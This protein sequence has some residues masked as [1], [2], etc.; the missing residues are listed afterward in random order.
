MRQIISMSTSSRVTMLGKDSIFSSLFLTFAK[1]YINPKFSSNKKFKISD[2]WPLNKKYDFAYREKI[3]EKLIKTAQTQKKFSVWKILF[4]GIY[5]LWIFAFICAFIA[6]LF[7]LYIPIGVD[8]FIKWL[9]N[10]EAPLSEGALIASGL[11]ISSLFFFIGKRLAYNRVWILVSSLGL[12]MKSLIYK[13]I[14]QSRHSLSSELTLGKTSNMV[15]NDCNN[16]SMT[17]FYWHQICINPFF[18]LVY[19]LLLFWNFGLV[20]L[21]ALVSGVLAVLGLWFFVFWQNVWT[22]RRKI[23]SDSRGQLF[24]LVMENMKFVKF[25]NW[26]D[27]LDN[28]IRSSR[29]EELRNLRM[30][31]F[32]RGFCGGL[33]TLTPIFMIVPSLIYYFEKEGKVELNNV[34]K[35]ISIIGLMSNPLLGCLYGINGVVIVKIVSERFSRLLKIKPREKIEDDQNVDKGEVRLENLEASYVGKEV[36][37]EFYKGQKLKKVLKGVDAIFEAGKTYCITG[38][39][40]S[41]KSA[42][43]DSILGD[44][45]ILK[46]FVKKNGKIAVSSQRSCL[47]SS[48]I[49]EN[50]ILDAE[51][52]EE[53]LKKVIELAQLAEDIENLPKGD[54]SL[55]GDNGAKLSGGQKQRICLARALYQGGDIYIF[56]DAFCGLDNEVKSEI[57][58][59]A[60]FGFLKRKTIIIVS[61]S[62]EVMRGA[63]EIIVVEQGKIVAKGNFEQVLAAG[64]ILVESN[65]K[66]IENVEFTK[67][68][69]DFEKIGEE[70]PKG[71]SKNSEKSSLSLVTPKDLS[72]AYEHIK[73]QTD[74]LRQPLLTIKPK[75]SS[76]FSLYF[77]YGSLCAFVTRSF[78]CIIQNACMFLISTAYGLWV[79]NTLGWSKISYIAVIFFLLGAFVVNRLIMTLLMMKMIQS[80]SSTMN[81]LLL[82]VLFKKNM[83]FFFKEDIGEIVNSG[84]RHF[85]LIDDELNVWID[86]SQGYYMLVASFGV[87]FSVKAF[88]VIPVL[89]LSVAHISFLGFKTVPIINNIQKLSLKASDELM[90]TVAD[91]SNNLQTLRAFNKENFFFEKYVQRTR[92][93]ETSQAS[94]KVLMIYMQ[95]MCE[96]WSLT[97]IFVYLFGQILFKELQIDIFN[98]SVV[99]GSLYA[100]LPNLPDYYG[101]SYWGIQESLF[102]LESLAHINKFVKIESWKGRNQKQKEERTRGMSQQFGGPG[103]PGSISFDKVIFR[104]AEDLPKVLKKVS[105]EANAGQKLALVGRTGSGKSSALLVL[106]KLL[107]Y[108]SGVVKVNGKKVEDV[109]PR[110]L[111]EEMAIIP[112]NP[113]L[114]FETLRENVDPTKKFKEE[115]VIE[116][117]VKTRFVESLLGKVKKVGDVDIIQRLGAEN[118]GKKEKIREI[119]FEETFET[120]EEELCWLRKKTKELLDADVLGGEFNLSSGQ[121]QIICLSKAVLNKPSILILDEATANLDLES[122]AFLQKVIRREFADRTILAVAH[123]VNTVLDFDKVVVL[124]AGKVMEEGNPKEL[125]KNEG[126]L[127]CKMVK[128]NG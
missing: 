90:G 100:I 62:L 51:L 49:R 27:L 94:I 26:E 92:D 29:D 71:N 33:F 14:L 106:S 124:G 55:V 88:Y 76:P 7:T 2:L 20:A 47:I 99:F 91:L 39:T 44:L 74:E 125:L 9:E 84:V 40:G 115:E 16:F 5:D 73:N 127:F 119:G 35:I 118:Y 19:F 96:V 113:V 61:H 83:K 56:D 89:L 105:F 13:I 112:Q 57:L 23:S 15:L 28:K 30:E 77:K 37:D 64:K 78:L 128:Q 120:V 3:L 36:L 108:E 72:P 52:D 101:L 58:K 75:S 8:Q 67:V 80:C 45:E 87:L 82:K 116:A 70:S 59:K 43:I 86:Y 22:K 31:W 107:D 4:K 109:Y 93:Y 68:N 32:N 21:V 104:Y 69:L 46:G 38:A 60:I 11:F 79:E 95:T 81:N 50:I 41:G 18:L 66:E 103:E 34:Y 54:F 17:L 97:I 102:R 126:S 65:E 24:A 12:Q 122:D 114:F 42:I 1:K 121:K 53:K 63:N 98:S 85:N 111:R 10:P 110:K 117:L 25:N 123:R 6:Q 48:N